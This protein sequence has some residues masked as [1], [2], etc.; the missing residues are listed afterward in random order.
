MKKLPASLFLAVLLL[1]CLAPLAWQIITALKPDAEITALPVRYWPENP[2]LVHFENLFSRRPFGRYLWNSFV[3]ATGSTILCL[4]LATPAAYALA[5]LRPRGGKLVLGL[6]VAIA[7]FPAI[8]FFFPIYEI[9]RA[10]GLINHPLALILPYA[11]F[12]LPLVVLFL[13]AYF[14][15]IPESLEEAAQIDGLGHLGVLTKMI[16]PLSAPAMATTAIMTFIACWNE[17][18]LAMT[19]LPRDEARTVTVAIA[20]LSGGSLFE[21]PWGLIGAA[22]ITSVAP[23]LVLVAFFQHRIVEGLTQGSNVG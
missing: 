5:R 22:I 10:L 1:W 8:T 16:L 2:T 6:L 21:L 15:T 3:I 14:R 13:T 7:F 23:L 20:A 11:T 19:F 12:N 17:F 4:A 18:L 9:I